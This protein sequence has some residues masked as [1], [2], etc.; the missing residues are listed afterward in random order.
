MVVQI[1]EFVFGLIHIHIH[2]LIVLDLIETN[3]IMQL[4]EQ[5]QA[6]SSL[7]YSISFVLESIE[8]KIMKLVQNRI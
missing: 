2:V 7:T 3:Q 6:K 8:S 4:S 1:L 5:S